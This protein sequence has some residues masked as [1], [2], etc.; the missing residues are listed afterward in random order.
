MDVVIREARVADADFLAW[1]MLTAARSHLPVGFWDIAFPGPEAPRL[2]TLADLAR[3]EAASFVR[4]DG[5]LVAEHEG[6]VVA[7][8]SAYDSATKSLKAFRHA[9]QEVLTAR[10]WPAPHMALLAQRLRPVVSC[11]PDTPPGTWVVE[12]VAATPESRGRGVA[13]RLLL[14]ILDRGRRAGYAQA[15]IAHLIGNDP[16]RLAYERVGFETVEERRDADFEA[17]LGTP[18]FARMLMKL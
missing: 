2:G 9:L 1:V 12:W 17:A 8:L 3:S 4:F 7:G 11:M 6:R 16:A 10:G 18:G 13:R 15:Q 5:F 14:E